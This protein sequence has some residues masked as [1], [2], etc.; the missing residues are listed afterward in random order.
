MIN[1]N[2]VLTKLLTLSPPLSPLSPPSL[3]P[4]SP[5]SPPSLPPLSSLSPPSLPPLS[6]LSPPSLPPL[7]PLSPPSLPPLPH[8]NAG[9]SRE[10]TLTTISKISLAHLSTSSPITKS[11]SCKNWAGSPAAKLAGSFVEICTTGISGWDCWGFWEVFSV[12]SVIETM[13]ST[14]VAPRP[15]RFCKRREGEREGEGEGEG[16]EGKR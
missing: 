6:P 12:W 4:L 13:I 9:Y 16:R 2:L 8:T 5:L 11:K 1:Y 15:V 3:P 14:P 10:A 7:S